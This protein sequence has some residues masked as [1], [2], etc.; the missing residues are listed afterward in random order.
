MQ[1][2]QL[3]M[4]AA[5]RRAFL[6]ALSITG[7]VTDACRAAGVARKTAYHWRYGDSEFADAWDEAIATAAD[8]LESEARRRAV[9]G[10]E[11][12]VFHRGQL[13]FK[14]DADTGEV[15]RDKHGEPIPATVSRRSDRLLEILLAAKRPEQFG[16]KSLDVNQ[17]VENAPPQQ[18]PRI[19]SIARAMPPERRERFIELLN[20][21]GDDDVRAAIA[22][23]G[24]GP[25][26]SALDD[27]F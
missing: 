7:V 23:E 24:A 8:G 25:P 16:R 1:N 15:L 10:V 12:P 4:S 17:R 26:P 6:D 22:L 13:V 18:M 2:A 14:R 5:R 11:E 27:A 21:V 3:T 20:M 19:E 9:D